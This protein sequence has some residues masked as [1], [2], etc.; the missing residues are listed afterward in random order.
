MEERAALAPLLARPSAQPLASFRPAAHVR[1]RRAR[2]SA[3]RD[4][5]LSRTASTRPSSRRGHA[6]RGSGGG[7]PPPPPPPPPRPPRPPPPPPPP[8]LGPPSP[9]C[10]RRPAARIRSTVG[11]PRASLGSR[12]SVGPSLRFCAG[13]AERVHRPVSVARS[14]S[15]CAHVSC[16]HELSKTSSSLSP[17]LIK[18]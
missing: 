13:S 12:V 6:G 5:H 2:P 7:P 9:A 16:K 3:P 11:P 8:P 15:V 17:F 10:A 14:A 4:P 1:H 18:R